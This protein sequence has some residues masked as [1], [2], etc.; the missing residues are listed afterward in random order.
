[1]CEYPFSEE[2]FKANT[3]E[4]STI[5]PPFSTPDESADYPNLGCS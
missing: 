4:F 3:N 2:I 5:K 1:M